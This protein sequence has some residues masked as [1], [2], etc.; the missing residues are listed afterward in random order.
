MSDSREILLTRGMVAIVDEADY[1]WLSQYSWHARLNPTTGR[2]YASRTTPHDENGKQ[3]TVRMHREIMGLDHGDPREVD[4]RE[5]LETL[6]NRRSNL[7]IATTHENSRNRGK[8]RN[9]KSGFKGVS[10]TAATKSWAAT[11]YLN[12]KNK[13]LGR[14][15]TAEQAAKAYQDA[16]NLHWGEFARF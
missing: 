9:N 11:I 7:R 1:E 3:K 15:P 6:D 4:H 16:A 2:Y 10:W 13:H 5:P 14:Y 12:G 8:F